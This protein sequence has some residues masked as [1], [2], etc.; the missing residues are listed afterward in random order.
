V[1]TSTSAPLVGATLG[2]RYEVVRHIARG[3]MGD[4]Y[5]AKDTLLGRPV[6]V[7]VYRATAGTDR[8]RFEAEV[9]TLASLNHPGLVQ[10]YDAGAHD[11][12]EYVVLELVDGPTLSA[13]IR[14]RGPLPPGEVA[15]LGAALAASLDYVHE[16]GVVH[17]D[18]SPSNVLRGSDGRP[19]LADFGIARLLDTTRVTAATTT[20]G[21]AAYMAPEQVEGRDVTPAADVYALG[22]VLR[23]AL[24]A[25]PA[26]HGTGH[27][28]ALAR[29]TRD[30]DVR[31]GIPEEWQDLLA[32]MT[33]RD[34]DARPTAAAVQHRLATVPSA[35]SPAAPVAAAGAVVAGAAVAA[36]VDGEAVTE[37]VPTGGGTTV[38]PAALRPEPPPAAVPAPLPPSAAA[39]GRGSRRALWIA[40]AAIALVVGIG[41]ASQGDDGVEPATSTTDPVVTQVPPTTVTT[42]PPTTRP[43]EEV[44]EDDGRGSGK[45]KGKKDD[46]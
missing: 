39:A 16:R 17:R 41:L 25:T 26:F 27:E 42:A 23:E 40:L 4:V 44:D 35:S 24:T 7:K 31:T 1:S 28:A 29:L 15:A 3:G 38:M 20:I 33:A 6:A 13:A 9:R 45:G 10:V 34:P 32:D 14:D 46:D 36:A 22:L 12:D 21:T 30:P 43:P 2:D 37:V 8:A 11:G 18:V 19:R 5:E